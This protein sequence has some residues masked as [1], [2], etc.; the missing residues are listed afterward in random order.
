MEN[1]W[2]NHAACVQQVF[3]VKI[4]QN[5]GFRLSTAKIHTSVFDDGFLSSKQRERTDTKDVAGYST[6]EVLLG[7]FQIDETL[8]VPASQRITLVDDIL[9]AG[10]QCWAMH[11][12]L[13]ERFPGMPIVGMFTA[14][15]VFPEIDPVAGFSVI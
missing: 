6:V 5:S 14:S 9:T 13:S 10:T 11:T 12:L 2:K 8:T 3:T 1:P 7:I 4:H 15:G